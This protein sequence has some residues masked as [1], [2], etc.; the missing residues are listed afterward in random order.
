MTGS[1]NLRRTS[2]RY[3]LWMGEVM[4][5]LGVERRFGASLEQWGGDE[6][7]FPGG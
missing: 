6:V 3:G 7:G 1:G 2:F 5:E 4:R